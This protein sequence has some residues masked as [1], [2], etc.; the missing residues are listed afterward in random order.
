[1]SSDGHISVSTSALLGERKSN[2]VSADNSN[3]PLT[4]QQ[5][6][7]NF[8]D[9]VLRFKANKVKLNERIKLHQHKKDVTEENISR[10]LADL[11]KVLKSMTSSDTEVHVLCTR[12]R[13]HVSVLEQTSRQLASRCEEHGAV[14]QVCS[15]ATV[16]L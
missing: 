7:D 3:V 1:M 12:L 9:A 10:E 16:C 6:E 15:T 5:L 4:S 13:Q 14:K 8:R 2:T 11:D